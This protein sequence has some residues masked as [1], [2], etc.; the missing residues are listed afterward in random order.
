MNTIQKVIAAIIFA[1]FATNALGETTRPNLYPLEKLE[2]KYASTNDMTYLGTLVTRCSAHYLTFSSIVGQNDSN[3]GDEMFKV[4]LQYATVATMIKALVRLDRDES[5]TNVEEQTETE[6][7]G[8]HEKYLEW[9]TANWF[10]YASYYEEDKKLA[11]EPQTCKRSYDVAV[12]VIEIE[13]Q[14]MISALNK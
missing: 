13:K 14:Q 2:Q 6:I 1:V 4:S 7:V 10:E 12:N 9:F 5:V 3:L 8:F 11:G